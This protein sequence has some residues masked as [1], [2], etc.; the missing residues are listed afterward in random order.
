MNQ[1]VPAKQINLFQALNKLTRDA[2]H[3]V[4]RHEHLQNLRRIVR[5]QKA[6]LANGEVVSEIIDGERAA[7]SEYDETVLARWHELRDLVDP[8]ENYEDGDQEEGD[9]HRNVVSVRL[10]ALIGG[11]PNGAPG[12]PEVYTRQLL[13]HVCAVEGLNLLALDTACREIVATKKFVPTVSEVMEVLDK[14][15]EKWWERL[16]TISWIAGTSRE[17]IAEIA[18]LQVIAEKAAKAWAEQQARSALNR[19]LHRRHRAVTEAVEAQKQAATAA[20]AVADKMAWLAK[21]EAEVLDAE[22]ELVKRCTA[23]EQQAVNDAQADAT[24]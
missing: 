11:F 8:P 21:C 1:I 22:Q 23:K 17:A 20:Q 12:D 16:R 14:H 15:L 2:D 5:Q 10:A 6:A 9:L 3:I 4:G 18:E 7:L 13:E 19:A 24:H